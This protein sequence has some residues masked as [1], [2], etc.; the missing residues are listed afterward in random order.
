MNIITSYTDGDLANSYTDTYGVVYSADKKRLLK[1]CFVEN[2]EVLQ[3]TEIICDCAFQSK[4]IE[5]IIL[6]DS[7]LAIGVCAFANNGRLSEIEIPQSVVYLAN[8]NPFGG[9]KSLKNI[10]MKSSNFVVDEGLI[11]SSDYRI[12]YSAL[13]V[14]NS[15]SVIFIDNRT[16]EISANCFWG[17]KGISTIVVPE[18]VIRIGKAAFDKSDIRYLEL[19]C[20]IETI[21]EHFM[22]LSCCDH[23]SLPN[24]IKHIGSKA[25]FMSTF[26]ELVVGDEIE[27]IGEYAFSTLYGL[28]YLKLNSVVSIEKYAFCACH[29][30]QKVYLEG[31]IDAINPSSFS[32]CEN[33]VEIDLPQSV[34][35]ICDNAIT[36]N[37]KLEYVIVNGPLSLVEE[38]NFLACDNLK[39]IQVSSEYFFDCYVA[40]SK[41]AKE[42]ASK[43]F[44]GK[45]SMN[46]ECQLSKL[47]E[48]LVDSYI[49]SS[50]Y[51][52]EERLSII[53]PD[54]IDFS[55]GIRTVG[56][57]TKNE[58]RNYLVSGTAAMIHTRYLKNDNHKKIHD[59][60]I[61][62]L[63][64]FGLAYYKYNNQKVRAEASI[65][66]V[67]LIIE[68]FPL[69]DDI[70]TSCLVDLNENITDAG[71][72]V[73]VAYIIEFLFERSVKSD[74]INQC[75][76]PLF[77]DRQ[78][79]MT[80]QIY[81]FRYHFINDVI[82]V[83]PSFFSTENFQKV[84]EKNYCL[85]MSKIRKKCVELSVFDYDDVH[86]ETNYV[87]KFYF[88]ENQYSI[89]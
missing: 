47:C 61:C 20:P 41:Y 57:F 84:F 5:S 25:F 83:C 35:T 10:K 24:S 21:P 23:L 75:Y 31:D 1:G 66:M 50:N 26:K 55:K 28:R 11:Y 46:K 52:N 59:G 42:V 34:R 4:D 19:K 12:L 29:D 16:K 63:N 80:K 9:C 13:F 78:D 58:N 18:S 14:F 77:E 69:L 45:I 81:G 76:I 86:V 87:R 32:R 38:G 71:K 48:K 22:S 67:R 27:S 62:S 85:F 70:I 2:Y 54:L 36:Q 30:L 39:E 88:K 40:I 49:Q 89:V 15:S 73:F 8:N 56:W 64:E 82:A 79:L 7:L 17:Q 37:A 68:Y 43:I 65:L 33:L 6:P 3:G 44:D 60:I 53:R 51:T 72:K 74:K